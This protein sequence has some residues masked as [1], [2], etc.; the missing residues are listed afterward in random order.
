MYFK[1][2]TIEA[3]AAGTKLLYTGS[4]DNI[5]GDETGTFDDSYVIGPFTVL[6]GG[7]NFFPVGTSQLGYTPATL[8]QGNGTDEIAIEAV[9]GDANFILDESI[10][11]ID[12]S[13]YW[14]ITTTDL[15]GLNTKITLSLNGIPAFNS[16]Y[17]P[18]VLQADAIASTPDNL[19]SVTDGVLITS[20]KIVTKPVIAIGASVEVNVVI[21]DIITPFL[22]DNANDQLYIENIDKFLANK[23]T[24]LDRWGVLVKEWTNFTNYTDPI[25]P[26]TDGYDFKKLSPGNY[27]CIVEYGDP[28]IGFS[29]KSQMITVLKA[30]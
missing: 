20:K 22:V 25:T 3:S 13:H 14:Q 17:S 12:H 24:L 1:T 2:G 30:K 16:D 19:L 10:P 23:V 15:A 27:I 6:A 9:D 18:V 11:E 4:A 26:N 7:K 5:S 28:D 21:H 29:K 8:E